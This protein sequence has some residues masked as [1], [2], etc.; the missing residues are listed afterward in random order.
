MHGAQA[1]LASRFGLT[2]HWE[3]RDLPEYFLVVAKGGPKLRLNTDAPGPE[4]S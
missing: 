4:I 3:T 2:F 1:L